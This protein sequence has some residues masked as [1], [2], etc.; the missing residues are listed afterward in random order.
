MKPPEDQGSGVPRSCK[1]LQIPGSVHR[2]EIHVDIYPTRA[3]KAPYFGQFGQFG[4]VSFPNLDSSVW[5]CLESPA[6]SIFT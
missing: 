1:Q 2:E 3:F 6:N 5:D 4:P